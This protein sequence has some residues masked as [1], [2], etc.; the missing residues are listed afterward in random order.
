MGTIHITNGENNRFVVQFPYSPERVAAVKKIPGRE[1]HPLKKIWTVPYSPK[2][3]EYIQKLF[4]GDRVVVA[5]SVRATLPE[6]P[7][8]RVK[9]FVAALDE[10]LTL[11]GYS[12]NT[13]DNYRLHMLR[14]LRWLRKDPSSAGASGLRAYLVEMLDSGLSASYVR[15]ARA[16]L[17]IY[18]ESVLNQPEKI[19][20]LPVAK[21]G[22]SLPLVLSKDKILRLLQCTANLK[23]ETFLSVVYSA[24][25]R[26]SE[27]SQ[28][29]MMII[30]QIGVRYGL[31]GA[32]VIKIAILSWLTGLCT[33]YETITRNIIPLIGC[34]PDKSLERIFPQALH[35]GFFIMR[36][37]K[38]KSIPKPLCTRSAIHS[39]HIC[40]KMVSMSVIFR[41]CWGMRISIPRCCIPCGKT[42][43]GASS[44]PARLLFGWRIAGVTKRN[45]NIMI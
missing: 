37:R 12:K 13:R 33:F 28:L 11:R 25:L 21:S 27:A 10:E 5:E 4:L 9:M 39:Q 32:K 19:A 44:Q 1:W 3:I 24:G 17:V 41:C 34:F 18:Y 43:L 31:L 16:M 22:K 30:F 26:S 2:V 23:S 42:A 15:Q 20:D 38:L 6:L 29:K 7:A 45:W 40:W 35:S 14:F 8:D 36:V